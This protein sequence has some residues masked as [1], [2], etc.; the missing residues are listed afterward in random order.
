MIRTAVSQLT[1]L[2][3][4]MVI[5]ISYGL[6]KLI[7]TF[8]VLFDLL[9]HAPIVF[10]YTGLLTQLKSSYVFLTTAFDSIVSYS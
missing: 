8:Y 9:P 3:G 4:Y 5:C 1:W 10:K 2:P 7:I 6:H